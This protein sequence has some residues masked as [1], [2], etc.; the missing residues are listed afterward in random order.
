MDGVD[1]GILRANVAFK[2][3]AVPA[4]QH[5]VEL[6]YDP[7]SFKLGAAVSGLAALAVVLALFWRRQ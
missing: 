3:V 6:V 1:T 7:A 4:G 2:A 5:L